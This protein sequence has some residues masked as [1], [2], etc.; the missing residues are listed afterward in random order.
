[1]VPRVVLVDPENPLNVGFAARAMKAFGAGDLVVVSSRWSAVPEQ[2]RV[3]GVSAPEVLDGARVT[4][5]L[6]EALSGCDTAVAFSRRPS[7]LRQQEFSLPDAPAL[8][9]TVAL[10]FGRES[11]GL[12]RA[13]SAL[14]PYLARI[15][16]RDGVSL[17]LGQAVSVALYALAAPAGPAV[18]AAPSAASLDRMNSLWDFVRERMERSPRFTEARRRRVRQMLYRLRLSDAD[19]DLLFSVVR[20]PSE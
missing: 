2:A 16:C 8:S 17:N 20:G 10:V 13:E 12:T 6:E 14:C 18:Q 4:P 19:F 7:A 5:S 9:G 15:P 11:A 3:T 1:M